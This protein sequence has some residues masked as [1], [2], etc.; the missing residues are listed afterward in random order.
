MHPK[1]ALLAA[2]IVKFLE[3]EAA[4]AGTGSSAMQLSEDKKEGLKG[5]T[6]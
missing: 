1:T 4:D 5:T 6:A 3:T 2:A